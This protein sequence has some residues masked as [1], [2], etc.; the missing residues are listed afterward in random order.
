MDNN[1]MNN[2]NSNDNTIAIASMVLG[3]IGV[4][5]CW[6]PVVGLVLGI[7]AL[8]LSI[9]GMK[10]AKYTNKGKGFS[11][12]G[13]SCGAVGTTLSVI[14]LFVWIFS[15]LLVKYSYD[16]YDELTRT[17]RT[18]YNNNTYVNRSYD[19]DDYYD[20]YE[21][22]ENRIDARVNEVIEGENRFLNS[23]DR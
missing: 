22:F 8:V 2:N 13:L 1:I 7:V 21:D 11:I 12:A 14:Y 9:K 5:T 4:I 3:I 17:N 15:V 19:Y 18:R 6:I 20:D 23:L 16:T 10:N